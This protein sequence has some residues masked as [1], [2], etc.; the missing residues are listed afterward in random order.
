M[1]IKVKK[2]NVLRPAI[3]Q[4]SATLY[5]YSMGYTLGKDYEAYQAIDLANSLKNY[6]ITSDENIKAKVSSDGTGDVKIEHY[7]TERYEKVEEWYDNKKGIWVIGF[8]L[9][10]PEWYA[11]YEKSKVPATLY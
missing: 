4:S 2:R 5:L 8:P 7:I 9:E 6:E 3:K 10:I 11:N 1:N